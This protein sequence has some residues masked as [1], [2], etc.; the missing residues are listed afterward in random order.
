MEKNN[1]EFDEQASLLLIT[2]MINKAQ[3]H[4][5]DRGFLYLMWGWVIFACSLVHFVL[6]H[7]HIIDNP[8]RIWV[9]TWVALIW[10]IFYIIKKRKEEK[11]KTYTSEII[12]QVWYVFVI[13]SALCSFLLVK[14]SAWTIM[15]PV[16]FVMYGIPIYLSGVIMKFM[17]LKIGAI[18]CWAISAIATFVA[19]EYQLLLLTAIMVI[20]WIIPGYLMQAKFK[21]A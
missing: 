6:L 20:A 13:C 1:E 9:L 21:S 2:G 4:F 18:C 10:Q 8:D 3:N 14:N 7:W 5:Q 19:A 15:Y 12:A 17:P 11:V 16:L